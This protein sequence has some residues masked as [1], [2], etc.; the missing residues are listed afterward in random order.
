DG[1]IVFSGEKTLEGRDLT[2]GEFSFQL[3]DA[4][5]KV[6]ETVKNDA[7]GKIAFSKITYTLADVGE[8]AYTVKEVTGE[9]KE[10]TYDSTVYEITV[11]VA[12]N[13]DGTLKVT[14]DKDVTAL[15]FANTYTEYKAE[16]E[17]VF[18][19]VKTLEGR[20][21]AADEFSFQLIDAEGKVIETVKND[22]DGKIAF[23]KITYTLAD[24]GEHAYTVKEVAGTD[25]EI[26][27]DSTVYEIT[28]TVEDNGDGTLNVTADKDVTA[29]DFVNTYTEYTADGE[30]VFS[31]VKT[32]E[33]R[34]L[35]T[36]EFSFQLIDAA[37]KVIET[38]KNDADGKI[39]FSKITYTLAD[40]GEHAYTVK[41]VVGTDGEIT[42][43]STVY[44]ITVTVEDNGDGT[45]NVTADKDVAALN[46]VNNYTQSKGNIGVMKV[47]S[48]D[49]T[50]GLAGAEFFVYSDAECTVKKGVIITGESGAGILTGLP[51]GTYYVKETKAPEGYAADTE[52]VY[53]VTVVKDDTAMVNGTYVTNDKLAS[54][55]LEKSDRLD[56][57]K[58]LPGAVYTVYTDEECL[59][60]H[61]FADI[62]TGEDGTGILENVPE[63]IY[64]V[65]ETKAPEGY[66]IDPLPYKV[67]VDK[68]A[69]PEEPVFVPVSDFPLRGALTLSKTVVASTQVEESFLFDV[70]LAGGN[71]P[72]E[73]SYE[74][75]LNGVAAE[76]VVFTATESGAKATVSLKD[77]E[78]MVIHGLRAGVTYTVTEQADARYE[79]Q[80]NG[81][82]ATAATGTITESGVSVA[83]FQNTLK[84]VSF[85][86]DKVWQGEDAG[87]IQ[88]TLYANGVAMDP[89]PAV[90][91]NGNTY[92]Y[93]DLAMVDAEGKEIVYTVKETAMAGYTTTYENVAPNADKTDC[94]YNGGKIINQALTSFSVKKEWSGLAQGETAPA[95]Q[96]TL[97]C[98]GVVYTASTPA[99]DA[100]GYYTYNDLPATV[101]GQPAVYTVK[102]TEVTG[103]T[104]T[105]VNKGENA[106]VTDCAYNGGTIVNTKIPQ[107]GDGTP[108]ALWMLMTMLAG[109]GLAG[110]TVILRKREN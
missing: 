61:K 10:I 25:G 76:N 6:V 79:T 103:F 45:L 63:G 86:V 44:E 3:I 85:T 92:T 39:A 40:V 16:G 4:A 49:T 43:D 77:N 88:L 75:T 90:T 11:T 94:A 41:E 99:P 29:L 34:D 35:A 26:T 38:V 48:R 55:K 52:K 9:D 62:T 23:S 96:L 71:G 101:N 73:G 8:H 30:I 51:V 47:D 87:E 50:K 21:L 65:K 19:G 37:G 80:V 15:N 24:V 56:P 72:V 28:V 36:D 17:I 59:P 109:C 60:E 70:E 54:L 82:Q 14:A 68:D 12:D 108:L 93:A 31:G 104:T 84:Q 97:Y 13:G 58:K 20:D 42:Y 64:W 32:L 66:E 57:E 83:R 81:A 78:T 100:N 1:E 5:G 107:T 102:E 98:N 46:F 27:Y 53:I 18:S 106:S 105:Y 89:Q 2:E 33:G 22:A 7:D 69:D 110:V 67:V 95:I 74:A 91:R